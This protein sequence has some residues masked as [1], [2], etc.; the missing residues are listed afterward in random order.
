VRAIAAVRAD[1]VG[2]AAGLVVLAIVLACFAGAPVAE[3]VLGHGP[4]D[5]F[6]YAVD[7][8]GK[9]VGPL[10]RVPDVHAVIE[11]EE[12]SAELPPP[13][14][15]A[16]D[17]VL[18]LGADGSLG[19]DLFLRMLYGGQ[20]TLLVAIGAAF[21]AT[22][23]GALIGAAGAYAGG[24]V[25]SAVSRATEVAMAFPVLLLLVLLGSAETPLRGVTFGGLVNDG[26]V[27]LIVVIACFTWFYP[28][29][30]VRA[31]VLA[32][33][34]SDF[35]A[36]ARMTGAGP[37][38]IVGRHL[39]PHVVPE[40]LPYTAILVATNVML[41]AG[42]SFLNA[43]IRLPTASWGTILSSSWGTNLSP[44]FAASEPAFQPWLT[45][46]P[47]LGIFVVVLCLQ[48][49]GEA[50]GDVVGARPGRAW[51]GPAR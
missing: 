18:L 48:L 20:V 26:V 21:L 4:N 28:A 31:R 11:E 5:P 24:W 33:R 29:R 45:V 51:A 42:V 22:T 32:L 35:V 23:I 10:T 44:Q 41:E 47:S 17:T 14:S 49:F 16:G 9:P 27:S 8:L 36:A 25:D 15:D 1:R 50:L 13:P 6:P 37:R 38:R 40:L 19:R 46:V 30:L 39:M 12:F 3:R 7:A 2:A 43:G 34:G